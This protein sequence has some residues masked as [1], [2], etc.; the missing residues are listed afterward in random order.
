MN[1][2][3]GAKTCPKSRELLVERILHGGWSVSEAAEAAGISRQTAYKW[4]GRFE[5]EGPEGLQDRSSAPAIRP[6]ALS[7]ESLA[8]AIALRRTKLRMRDVARRLRRPFSTIARW[9]KKA[10][11]GK[12]KYLDP[13]EPVVR[14]EYD[15]PGGLLHL[16]IKKLGRFSAPG[17]RMTGKRSAWETGGLGWEYVLVCVDDHSRAA[18]VEV[19]ED[20]KKESTNAFLL[21]AVRWF[22]ARGVEVERI[23]T[24]NGPA[25]HSKLVKRSCE[26]LGIRHIFT[27]PY[28]PQ[29]NGKAERFIQT[30]LRE[31]IYGRR[32]KSSGRRRAGLRRWNAYYNNSRPHRSLADQ[33]PITRLMCQ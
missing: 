13:K 29:T 11:L 22:Q 3:K 26:A 6:K 33:A 8:K 23:I 18:Y 14:Y 10:G 28:R 12:L 9:L 27:R 4:V 16:D 21:R 32:Y 7:D 31:C 25:Y 20:E 17:H 19:L 30:M 2:H 5:A 1:I 24:D 15:E